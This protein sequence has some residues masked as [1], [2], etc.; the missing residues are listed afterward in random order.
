MYFHQKI[1]QIISF[2]IQL[3]FDYK[4]LLVQY[5]NSFSCALSDII[6]INGSIRIKINV[7]LQFKICVCVLCSANTVVKIVTLIYKT[8]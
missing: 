8:I 2:C 1:K 5:S 7:E 4:L 3:M 6:I